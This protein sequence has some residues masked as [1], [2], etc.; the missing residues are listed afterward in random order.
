MKRTALFFITLFLTV[1]AFAGSPAKVGVIAGF[2]SSQTNL[3]DISSFKGGFHGGVTA[4]LPLALGFTV[5][6]SLIYQ[7]K[8]TQYDVASTDVKSTTGYL[9]VP[10]QIQYGVDLVLLRPYVFAEPFV[11]YAVNNKIAYNSSSSTNLWDDVNRFEYGL[12]L[13][14]GIDL[15]GGAQIAVK[16]FWNFNDVST[17]GSLSQIASSWWSE[18]KSSISEKQSFNGIVVSLALFF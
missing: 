8:G 18:A 6:P 9:E 3:E 10:V 7:Q 5:Q 1:S 2:T 17:E 16:Y 13:G 4:K 12:G 11:G 15:G 14:A